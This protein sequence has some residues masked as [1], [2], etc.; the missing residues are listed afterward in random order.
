MELPTAENCGIASC[1]H[2][3]ELIEFITTVA[4]AS[5]PHAFWTTP[6]HS[7]LHH[8][9][10]GSVTYSPSLSFFLTLYLSLTTLWLPWEWVDHTDLIRQPCNDEIC[11]TRLSVPPQTYSRDSR[12]ELALAWGQSKAAGLDLPSHFVEE[13]HLILLSVRARLTGKISNGFWEK[14]NESVWKEMIW[15]VQCRRDTVDRCCEERDCVCVSG[16][17]VQ[18]EN[19]LSDVER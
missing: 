6:T 13:Q 12:S 8:L 17:K 4:T 19:S 14:R 7:S 1:M 10:T 18:W 15:R 2:F 3:N 16:K 5:P 11:T 9:P